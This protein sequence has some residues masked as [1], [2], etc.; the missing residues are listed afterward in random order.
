MATKRNALSKGIDIHKMMSQASSF[1]SDDKKKA[2]SKFHEIII[3]R[4]E[5]T[6]TAHAHKLTPSGN[7]DQDELPLRRCALLDLVDG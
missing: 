3:P 5:F 7:D 6:P 1:M 4:S 2:T